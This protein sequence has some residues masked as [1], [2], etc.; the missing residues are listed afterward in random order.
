VALLLGTAIAVW[1]TTLSYGFFEA[2]TRLAG[3]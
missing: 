2:W 3:L 1:A